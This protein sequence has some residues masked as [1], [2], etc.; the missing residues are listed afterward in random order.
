MIKH[1]KGNADDIPI[2]GISVFLLGSAEH[3]M[4]KMVEY[5]KVTTHFGGITK[6]WLG[7]FLYFMVTDPAALEVVLKNN[8]EKDNLHRFLRFFVGNALIFAPVS[9]W[10]PRRKVAV[11]AFSPKIIS[12]FVHVFAEQSDKLAHLLKPKVGIGKFKIWPHINAYNLD[13]V[14]ETAMGVPLNTQDDYENPILTATNDAFKYACERIFHPWLQPDWLYKFFPQYTKLKKAT[15]II[16]DFTDEVI[17]KKKLQLKADQ[18]KSNIKRLDLLQNTD[19]TILD[20][21]ISQSGGSEGY[22][23]LELREEV[24]TFIL[25]AT[26]TSAVTMGFTL[27]L[28]GK[29]PEIQQKVFDEIDAV[30][31]DSDRLLDKDDLPKLQYLERVIKETLRLYP[32]VPLI[33]RTTTEESP[34]NENIVLPKGTGIVASIYGVHRNPNV[35]GPDVDCFDPDRFLPE[36]TKGMHPCSFI[37]FSHGPR[38]C[39]G[40]QYAMISIKTALSTILRRYKVIDEPEKGPIPNIRVKLD[41]MMKAVDGYEV[42]LELREK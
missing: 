19:I 21:L 17:S 33:I 13:S 35:W 30:F 41:V 12:S 29:Y 6:A 3:I 9:I 24:L 16:H 22:T 4:K 40:Y 28:L 20:L 15:K 18:K 1:V 14:M 7:P 23:N 5:S 27:K 34:L 11:P 10:K 8:L 2:F 39:L 31:G 38:N 37:P 32:S 25:A 42:A 26:D 36:R